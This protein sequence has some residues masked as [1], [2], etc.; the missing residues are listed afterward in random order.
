[1]ITTP[2]CLKSRPFWGA[3]EGTAEAQRIE[4]LTALV[5]EYEEEHYPMGPLDPTR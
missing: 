4:I 2:L 3:V 1:M 5:E